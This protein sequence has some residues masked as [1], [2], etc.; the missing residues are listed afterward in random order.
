MENDQKPTIQ[1]THLPQSDVRADF[2][3]LSKE[4]VNPAQA[5]EP[6]PTPEPPATPKQG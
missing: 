4:L 2:E 3:R 6:I 5:S 1:E